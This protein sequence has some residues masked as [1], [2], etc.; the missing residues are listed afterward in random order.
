LSWE[1]KYFTGSDLIGQKGGSTAI[2]IDTTTINT[3]DLI[4]VLVDGGMSITSTTFTLDKS[5]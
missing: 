3:L 5:R 1:W 2:T 4:N